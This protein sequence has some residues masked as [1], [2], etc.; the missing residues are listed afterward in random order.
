LMESMS[1]EEKKEFIETKKE[2]L[3]SN[4]ELKE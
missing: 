1:D 3:K 4:K 2:E